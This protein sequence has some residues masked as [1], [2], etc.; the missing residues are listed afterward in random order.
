MGLEL[1]EKIC[2]EWGPQLKN[3]LE[4]SSLESCLYLGSKLFISPS[5]FVGAITWWCM[6]EGQLPNVSFLAKQ[7]FGILGSQIEIGHVFSLVGGVDS[8]KVATCKWTTWTR[9]SLL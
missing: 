2:V 7:F 9:L 4:H 5:E 8:F 6:Y 3:L 1:E